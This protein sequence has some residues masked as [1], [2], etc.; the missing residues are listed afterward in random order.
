MSGR[1]SYATVPGSG[2]PSEQSARTA[3][4]ARYRWS[5]SKLGGAPPQRTGPAG[6]AERACRKFGCLIDER[7]TAIRPRPS[8]RATFRS[9][10]AGALLLGLTGCA[11]DPAHGARDLEAMVPAGWSLSDAVPGTDAT[12]LIEWWLRFNDPQLTALVTEAL[13]SNTS[14][15][16]AQEA[17]RSSRAQRD[18]AAAAL[19]PVVSASATAQHATADGRSNGSVFAAG[20][21]GSW[22]PD[23]F[24]ARRAALRAATAALAASIASLGDVQ[25]SVAAEV[26]V[27][28]ILLRGAQARLVIATENLASQRETLQITEWRQQAGL[29][30]DLESAQARAL[31]EQTDALLPVLQ[32][33]ITQAIH[34]LALLT[35]RAP[36]ALDPLLSGTGPV[37]EANDE[38]ALRIP[39]ETLRQRADVR[40]AE[41]DR[42]T[43]SPATNWYHNVFVSRLIIANQ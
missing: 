22:V 31:A 30:T 34:A 16:G 25:V 24:G 13:R 14:I 29:V 32:T 9:L 33:S 4:E 39:A 15:L 17:V 42:M 23:V 11:S 43:S 38:L 1:R 5:V 37:P 12:P 20:L 3:G 21:D 40:A 18:L 6:A 28:Y 41:H 2:V 35:G 8:G 10:A 36:A 19:W 26:G 7:V 27:D